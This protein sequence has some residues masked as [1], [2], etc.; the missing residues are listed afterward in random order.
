VSPPVIP[1]PVLSYAPGLSPGL[2]GSHGARL[3][4]LVVVV[5]VLVCAATAVVLVALTDKRDR[6][7]AIRAAAE[8]IRALA[9]VLAAMLPW[10][11]RRAAGGG[12][13]GTGGPA[14]GGTRVPAAA[15]RG[16]GDDAADGAAALPRRAGGLARGGAP[17]GVPVHGRHT[18][19][20]GRAGS[21]RPR[22]CG[23]SRTDGTWEMRCEREAP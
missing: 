12:R 20:C 1:G 14:A 17:L 4:A 11:R 3:I 21:G 19:L 2:A 9:D 22:G 18:R 5:A 6:P 23:Y 16:R 7:E 15:G 8:V 13:T 10:A